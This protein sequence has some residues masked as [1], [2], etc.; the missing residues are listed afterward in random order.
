VSL[1]DAL[2]GYV[3]GELIVSSAAGHDDPGT[4][5]GNTCCWVRIG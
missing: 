3:G 2:P 1:G 5:P 4:L